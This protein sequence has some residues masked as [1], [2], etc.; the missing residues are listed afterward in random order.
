[1]RGNLTLSYLMQDNEAS[2]KWCKVGE[3][4][5]HTPDA[6]AQ[7]ELQL[8]HEERKKEGTKME[9]GRLVRSLPH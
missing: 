2:S 4:R 3:G 6:N 9:S 7:K 8:Q 5:L 1:M